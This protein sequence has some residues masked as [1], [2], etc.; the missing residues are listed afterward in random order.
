M[1]DF[2][3]LFQQGGVV[4]QKPDFKQR[5]KDLEPY[6]QEMD[7][8]FGTLGYGSAS[9]FITNIMGQETY[10]GSPTFY[11]KTKLHSM[12]LSQV[13]PIRYRDLITD[14]ADPK[15]PGW[16]ARAKALNDYMQAK[17]GY[18][19]WDISKLATMKGDKYTGFSRFVDDPL[20]NFMLSRMLLTKDKKF[21]SYENLP[22]IAQAGIWKTIWNTMSG[23]GQITDF[24]KKIADYR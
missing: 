15:A 13:D 19:D 23:K 11:D 21:S 10:Y 16:G 1:Y 12:G 20:T 22:D 17:P 18:K 7:A 6:G 3:Q 9:D 2:Y 24:T 14:I 4:K 5:A 8:F